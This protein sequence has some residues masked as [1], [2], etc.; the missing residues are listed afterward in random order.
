MTKSHYGVLVPQRWV[1][2]MVTGSMWKNTSALTPISVLSESLC[3]FSDKQS[4]NLVHHHHHVQYVSIIS[5]VHKK[6]HPFP[7]PHRKLK[8]YIIAASGQQHH[9]LMMQSQKW[10][11]ELWISASVWRPLFD[12]GFLA[13][14]G[15]RVHSSNSSALLAKNLTRS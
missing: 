12:S 14:L 7:P 6:T 4:A 11:Q 15:V 2:Y 9:Y 13:T 3:F 1:F 5:T 8:A 10:L